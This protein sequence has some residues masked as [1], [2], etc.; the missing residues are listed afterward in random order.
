MIAVFGIWC[1]GRSPNS[2]LYTYSESVVWIEVSYNDNYGKIKRQIVNVWNECE[3]VIPEFDENGNLPPGVHFCEWEEFNERF[4]TNFKR[5]NMIR[6]L[7]L[8]MTQLKA[9]GCR[10][11][12]INGSFVTSKPD[13]NDF[14]ACY[15]G[16]TLDMDD[17]RVNAP[18]LF[19]HH[20]RDA[21]KAKYRGEIFPSD[22]PVGNYGDNSFEFFQKD[23][24]QRKK[25]IIAIDIMRW[26][27]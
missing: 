16:E 7:K 20:D 5:E 1:E 14:D 3:Q 2:F 10:T 13:P 4:G 8:A 21:Q 15:D 26:E 22:Q 6:G 24:K 27:P 25:G 12:Y 23:R 9:A 19:N 17:L 11:I 18:R